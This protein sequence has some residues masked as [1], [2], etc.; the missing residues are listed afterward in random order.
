MIPRLSNMD[1]PE[2]PA[3]EGPRIL[4]LI[5]NDITVKHDILTDADESKDIFTGITSEKITIGGVNGTDKSTVVVSGD[6]QVN[7]EII[8]N[9]N[10]V[11]TIFADVQNSDI[12]IASFGTKTTIKGDLQFLKSQVDLKIIPRQK[13]KGR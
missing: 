11:K 12:Q 5:G 1:I 2:W 10:E 7:N 4:T 8:G 6:L 13:R 3:I 9:N